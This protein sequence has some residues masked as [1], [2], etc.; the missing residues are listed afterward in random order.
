MGS[1]DVSLGELRVQQLQTELTT[2]FVFSVLFTFDNVQYE[3]SGASA[4]V[5]ISTQERLLGLTCEEGGKCRKS[6]AGLVAYC[7]VHVNES[8]GTNVVAY[9]ARADCSRLFP[10]KTGLSQHHHHA[11]STEH[12]A[13][14]LGR[15]LVELID[16]REDNLAGFF[17]KRYQLVVTRQHDSEPYASSIFNGV[18]LTSPEVDFEAFSLDNESIY[19]E[20]IVLWLTVGNIHLPRHEDLPNTVTSGGRLSFFVQ[21]HNLFRHS[22]DAYSCDRVYTNTC[23]T[24][25]GELMGNLRKLTPVLVGTREKSGY[26]ETPLSLA[27]H[28][29]SVTL[30]LL[31]I[32]EIALPDNILMFFKQTGTMSTKVVHLKAQSMGVL[33]IK[34]IQMSIA[35]DGKND[36][37]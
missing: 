11:H 7:R 34:E 6:K 25:L 32:D 4:P 20:D 26:K 9:L 31:I 14:K 1:P 17:L 28:Q 13:A 22:P 24:L 36:N 12:N 18:D 2:L 23:I 30:M 37:A 5:P 35:L 29:M 21:P 19:N 10:T 16:V 33:L 27:G 3:S 15:E 8:G